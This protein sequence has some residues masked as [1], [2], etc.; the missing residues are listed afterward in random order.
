MSNRVILSGRLCFE[1]ELKT[2]PDGTEVVSFRIAVS[3][4]FQKDKTDFFDVVA[5]RKTAVFFCQYF[6]KGDGIEVDGQL[7]TRQ[8]QA[9]DGTNRTVVEIHADNVSFPPSK[10]KSASDTTV[11]AVPPQNESPVTESSEL[12]RVIDD[13]LP[14]GRDN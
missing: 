1:P 9:K 8:Y 2:T 14:F 6:H 13:D 7:Q 11:S 4:A 10:G 3:R 12:N 5:W